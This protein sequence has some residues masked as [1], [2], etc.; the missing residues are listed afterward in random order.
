LAMGEPIVAGKLQNERH[1]G[2]SAVLSILI[3]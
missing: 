3:R 2:G 1:E